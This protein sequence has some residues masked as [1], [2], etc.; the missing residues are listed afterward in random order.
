[1]TSPLRPPLAPRYGTLDAW[2]G[3]ACLMVVVLHASLYAGYDDGPAAR[4]SDP[5]GWTALSVI[6]RL[7]VGV[8]VFFVISGYCI[9]ATADATRRRAGGMGDYFRRRFR[10]IFPPYWAA[11]A[12]AGGLA[13]GLAAAG[14]PALIGEPGRVDTGVI[15]SPDSLT[16]W[17]WVGNLTLT[18][19]WR[20]HLGGGP[21]AKV[22]G[23]SWTLCYEEQFYLVGGLLLLL[24]GRWFFAGVAVVSA[25]CLPVAIVGWGQVQGFFF[26][27]RWLLFAAG[28]GVYYRVNY[29]DEP[30][31][32]WALWA[33]GSVAMAAA[34]ARYGLAR[35][36]S[37]E[38]KQAL[39]E[40]TVG[41]TFAMALV[42]GHRLDGWTA[43]A[44]VLS[45]L[46]WCGR[47][48]YSLY[49]VHWPVTKVLAAALFAAGVRGAWPVLLAVVPACLGASA[50]AAAVF[51]WAVERR[52][53][54]PRVPA[55]AP[56]DP[57]PAPTLAGPA[58]LVPSLLRV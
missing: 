45:P 24:S 41:F 8:Q 22:L 31:S 14:Y 44:R 3:L 43:R 39:F 36:A 7:G 52:F 51:L 5:V 18:E 35:G 32:R 26:D 38:L 50:A 58:V 23:P 25:L 11:L 29:P 6:S 9:A 56:P 21:E 48:C 30:G 20:Y 54:N 12:L 53:L 10:R 42:V 49:L 16:P 13:V 57:A 40:Y 55:P 17:Q 34:V 15:L 46:G 19:H 1:M 28:V 37:G 4:S 27:G 47:R 33:M 2:R